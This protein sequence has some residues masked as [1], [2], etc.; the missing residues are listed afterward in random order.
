[1]ATPLGNALD[2]FLKRAVVI[3]E[4]DLPADLGV[5][6]MSHREASKN[7]RVAPRSAIK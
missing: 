3:S 1:M 5:S 4:Q 2:D 6:I 7:T